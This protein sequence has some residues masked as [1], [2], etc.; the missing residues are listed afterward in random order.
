VEHALDAHDFPRRSI[1]EGWVDDDP[2]GWPEIDEV[3]LAAL[4]DVVDADGMPYGR[5]TEIPVKWFLM[6]A[7]SDDDPLAPATWRDFLRSARRIARGVQA[8]LDRMQPDVVVLT[9]GLFLFEAV[10]WELCRRR[11]IDVVTYE[12]GFIKETLVF[13]RNTP[14][15]L[16]D[17]DQVWPQFAGVALTPDEDARLDAY[18][19]ERRHGRRTIDRYWDDARFDTP[20]RTG[21]GRLVTLFTNLTWDSAVIGKGVA[22]ASI[23]EWVATVVELFRHRPEHQLV[24]RLHPAEVKLPGKETR[25]P[26]LPF[27]L[28][29]FGTLPPNVRVVAPDDPTSSYPL[30]EAADVGLVFT[31]TTG[32]E[33][34]LTGTPVIVAGETHY[35]GKGFTVDVSTSEELETAL[36]AALADPARFA[37]DVETVRRYAHLFFFT[38]PVQS[39]GVEEHVLGLARLTVDSLDDLAPGAS[40][41]V[42]RICDGILGRADVLAAP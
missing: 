9:N 7:A 14:A 37:P 32:M 22:F 13:R 42:D 4:R 24:I 10:T 5:L 18:L 36:D 33:L 15:C 16:T 12:R 41:A 25:E 30:M 6:R 19:E 3:S 40:E 20:D 39:P 28:E 8:A 23:Q 1:R 29:R 21:E 26:M 35:R 17:L 38:S 34:A 27:L 2:G 11:G 31:S